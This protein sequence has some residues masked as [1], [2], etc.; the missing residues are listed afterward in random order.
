MCQLDRIR[1]LRS[2]IYEIARKHKADKVYVF[3]SCARMEETPD[4]DVYATEL[5]NEIK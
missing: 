4:S 1:S 5:L 3:G 2:E